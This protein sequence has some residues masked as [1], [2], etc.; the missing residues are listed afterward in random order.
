M[1]HN[2]SDTHAA[3]PE[4]SRRDAGTGSAISQKS[5]KAAAKKKNNPWLALNLSIHLALAMSGFI[6]GAIMGGIY[7]DRL[8]GRN[9]LFVFVMIP[10]GIGCGCF[11][12]WQ[13]IK[14]E[15]P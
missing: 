1:K 13:I 12:A 10:I 9:G 3:A 5:Q 7:L 4:S 8:V 2:D 6:I 11:S 14:R 15:L